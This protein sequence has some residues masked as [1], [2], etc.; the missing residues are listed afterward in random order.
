MTRPWVQIHRAPTVVLRPLILITHDHGN[1]RAQRDSKLCTR[2]DLHAVFLI[3][4][5]RQRRLAGSPPRHL[6]LDVGF[7]EGEPR[8][9]A[10]NDAAHGAAVGLAVSGDAEVGAEGRHD[11]G[12]WEE[13]GTVAESCGYELR[14]LM[15]VG[16]M[17]CMV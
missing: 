15:V 12:W 3:A 14:E 7:C 17:M 13:G 10:I 5:C 4:R 9:H 6:R 16:D 1:R 11:G 2:L 8:W